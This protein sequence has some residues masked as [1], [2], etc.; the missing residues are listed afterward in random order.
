LYD[1]LDVIFDIIL[2]LISSVVLGLLWGTLGSYLGFLVA[3][4]AVGY[5]NRQNIENGALRG[6]FCAVLAG[7][8]FMAAMFLMTLLSGMGPGASMM[9]MG[10][11][12]MIIGLMVV[13][14]IGS[15]GGTLGWLIWAKGF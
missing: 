4:M 15:V 9:E 7:V 13:G 10:I 6:A 3:T 5:R 8:V 11:L 2:V 12:A 14:L 1:Y